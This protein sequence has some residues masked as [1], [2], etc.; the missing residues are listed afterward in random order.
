MSALSSVRVSIHGQVDVERARREARTLAAALGFTLVDAEAV[1]LS[2]SELATNLARYAAG[3]VIDV[4]PLVSGDVIGVQVNS[5]DEG[6]GIV[7]RELAL[8]GG[9]STG[10]GLGVGLAGV[11]RL[12]DEFELTTGPAGT[13]VICRKWRHAR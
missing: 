8:G 2:V 1:R 5:R 12:M 7:D 4:Q 13:T 10:G 11:R 9:F 3:G 6:P